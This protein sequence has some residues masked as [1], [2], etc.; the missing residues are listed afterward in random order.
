MIRFSI[1][2]PVY[3]RQKEIDELLIK[4]S[5]AVGTFDSFEILIVDDGSPQPIELSEHVFCRTF[6]QKIRLIRQ[7]KQGPGIARNL[8]VSLALGRYILFLDS[9]DCFTSGFLETLNEEING[10][11]S[12][13]VLY[14]DFYQPNINDSLIRRDHYAFKDISTLRNSTLNWECYQESMFAA[15]DREFLLRNNLLFEKGFFEDILFSIRT[16][17]ALNHFSFLPQK[18][19]KKNQTKTSITSTISRK[20]LIDYI[21]VLEAIN[22]LYETGDICPRD[23]EESRINWLSAILSRVVWIFSLEIPVSIRNYWI[24]EYIK[25][26]DTSEIRNWRSFERRQEQVRTQFI[27]GFRRFSQIDPNVEESIIYGTESIE[28]ILHSSWSCQDLQGSVYFAPNEVRTCCK[29]FFRNG[30]LAGDVVLNTSTKTQGDLVDLDFV[31]LGEI[32]RAKRDLHRAINLGKETDCEGCP[33]LEFKEWEPLSKKLEIKYLSMEQH[34]V[35]NLRCVY[36]DE[37]YYGG[38]LPEYDVMKSISDCAANGALRG[39]STVVWGGGE[40]TLDR[41]FDAM[42]N[43][44][45]DIAPKCEHR[46]LTNGLRYSNTIARALSMGNSQVVTSIDSGNEQKYIEIRGRKGFSKAL[47]NLKLYQLQSKGAI[48]IKYIFTRG[49]KDADSINSFVD[50]IK[51]YQLDRAFFQ[52]SWDFKEETIQKTDFLSILQLFSGLYEIGAKLTFLDDLLFLRL[53]GAKSSHDDWKKWLRDT[54]IA[55]TFLATNEDFQDIILF[56][57]GKQATQV[58]EKLDILSRW[59]ITKIVESVVI[60][61]KDFFGMTVEP[62]EIIKESNSHVLI[63]G[64]Q[65]TPKMYNAVL[66]LGVRKDRIIRKLLI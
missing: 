15:Y 16:V 52:I 11:N 65:S 7:S 44:I 18:L 19:Y 60:P 41:N 20:H 5:T 17:L 1:I 37:K 51:N 35:C 38:A 57:A 29:R 25:L 9:D 12:P 42:L 63:L 54:G 4:L 8:G 58:Q 36:C 40:P 3:S 53:A 64:V 55:E 28:Q 23:S 50:E 66:N 48:T 10:T 49:N 62:L 31:P 21:S 47:Q 33:F 32:H 2:V 46:F 26:L 24:S 45:L 22:N 14:F 27:L 61:G 56:G 30:K 39:L 6:L 13:E 59:P 43:E 34:S